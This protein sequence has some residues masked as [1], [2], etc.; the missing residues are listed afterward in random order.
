MMR[1]SATLLATLVVGLLLDVA[2][3]AAQGGYRLYPWCAYYGGGGRGGATNC[4]FSTFEQCQAAVSGTGG[5]CNIN[6]WYAAYG[7]YYAFGGASPPRQY[8][9]RR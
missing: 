6:T 8:R 2:P 4:Y 5:F 7:P 1:W 9:R 3:A